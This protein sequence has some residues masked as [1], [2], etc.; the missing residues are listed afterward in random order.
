MPSPYPSPEDSND[1]ANPYIHHLSAPSRRQ[2]LRGGLGVMGAQ[3][4]AALGLSACATPGQGPR[5]ALGFASVAVNTLDQ[6]TVPEGYEAQ[7]LVPWGEPVGLSGEDPAFKW[8]ASNTAAEQAAQLGMHHDG[9]QY[10]PLPALGTGLL[11]I[12]HEYTDD[13]LLHRDG[14]TTWTAEKVRKSQAAHGLS[15]VEVTQEGGRWRS[16]RPSP[17][18]R[19]IT[20]N[21]PMRFSGP[22]AGHPLLR[23]A[24]DPQGMSPMGT[25]NNCGNGLTPWGTVLTT[26][27]NFIGYF[28]GPA[29]PDAHGKRWGLRSGGAGYRWHEHDARFDATRHPNE[30]NRF[31]WI[32]EIDPQD[33]SSVPVKRTALGRGS[34]EAARIVLTREGRAVVYSGEDARFEYIYKFVSRDRMQPGGAKANQHLL[35]HGTLYVAR[36]D[37]NGRGQWMPLTHGSHQLDTAHGFQDAGDVLIKTRQASDA[38]GA[39]KMDRPEWI[40]VDQQ[41]WVYVTLTNNTQRGVGDAPGVDAANPRANNSMGHIIRWK[42]SGDFDAT[43]FEWNHLVLAGDPSQARPQAKGTIQGDVFACPDGL[44]VDTRGVLWIQTDISSN[45]IAKGEMS[46]LG[47]NALLAVDP[48][49]GQ[50]RRFLVGPAGCEIT[51]M[52]GTPDGTT[53]F[54]NIQHP[55]ETPSERSDPN[56]PRQYSNWPDFRADGRPRSATLAIRKLDGGVVGT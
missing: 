7:V 34:H 30:P 5:P 9:I 11:V 20:A 29:Q 33:P 18:A 8:D 32:V 3:G 12:N 50:I 10:L 35:D 16:V 48:R 22:A 52:T 42:E 46:G 37:A 44:W 13:G 51:G 43:S 1:S 26:E 17:F 23:T 19:R 2:V 38:L 49:S 54:V 6:V 56:R 4:L 28:N 36:F 55:G 53:V 14:M 47:H 15:I 41:G 21:T 40:E 31:G 27:E 45:T 25:F 39:T 24:A